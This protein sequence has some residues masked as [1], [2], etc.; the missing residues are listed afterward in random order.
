MNK[1]PLA[2]A[3]LQYLLLQRLIVFVY[4]TLARCGL[5]AEVLTD[6]DKA[7]I[8]TAVKL[9]ADFIAISFVRTAEDILSAKKLVQDAGGKAHIVAKIERAEA[10]EVAEDIIMASDAVMVA[11]GDLGVEVGDAIVPGLQKRLINL[12]RKHHKPVIT[13]TQMMESMINNPIPTR[14][15]VSDVANAV[16]DGTD[17]VMLSAETASGTYPIETIMAVNR[18][19][20]DAE[21]G[22]FD[23]A[24]ENV[25]E[26]T[27]SK[28]DESIAMAAIYMA[29]HLQVMAI[30]TLTQSGNTARW[31]SRADNAVPIYAL[32]PDVHARRKLSLCRGVYPFQIEHS[33]KS[34]DKILE[35]MQ[36]VLLE[37]SAVMPNDVVILTFGE[38]IGTLGGT[39]TLKV[40][41]IN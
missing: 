17:A 26:E 41:T 27:F 25:L 9:D 20:L 33:N 37:H 21:K 12:S 18:V 28:K 19:V 39:N 16:L 10:I 15:E 32:S 14:A 35:E 2:F 4:E 31:L 13:A 36:H 1:G 7:D 24:H 3:I 40:V 29:H 8:I 22:Y 23:C 5:A 11:R 30:A 34:R 6:K 38:P